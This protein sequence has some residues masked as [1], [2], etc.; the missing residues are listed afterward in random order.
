M[1]TVDPFASLDLWT[2]VRPDRTDEAGEAGEADETDSAA[3]IDSFI[4]SVTSVYDQPRTSGG[5][6]QGHRLAAIQIADCLAMSQPS[7]PGNKDGGKRD[8]NRPNQPTEPTQQL[9]RRLTRNFELT[10]RHG[11]LAGF[12]LD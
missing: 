10:S 4:H 1:V 12:F 9:S 7:L 11:T 5:R 3:F 8:N 6:G 2:F